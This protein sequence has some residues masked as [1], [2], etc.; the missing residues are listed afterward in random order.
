[1]AAG[2]AVGT[3]GVAE[4]VTDPESN[5]EDETTGGPRNRLPLF[6]V[7]SGSGP[8]SQYAPTLLRKTTH[9]LA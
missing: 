4:I 2:A 1:M 6:H 3:E 8:S 7:S 5:L 9:R